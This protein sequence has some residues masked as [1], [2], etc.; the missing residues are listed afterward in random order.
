MTLQRAL[1]AI[2]ASLL[3][4]LLTLLLGGSPALPAP[5]ASAQTGPVFTA[6]APVGTTETPAPSRRLA[7]PTPGPVPVLRAFDKPAQNWLPGHRGVDLGASGDLTAPAAGTVR[8][9]GMLAGRGVLSID[10]GNGLIT[11]FEPVDALV[12]RGSTVAAGQ[13]VARVWEP[14]RVAH[15]GATACFHLGLRL[16]G[17]YVNPLLFLADAAEP[18]RLLPLGGQRGGG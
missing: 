1:P 13:V 6:A 17:E 5:A 14:G 15:C 9:A 2:T 8:F 7:W 16:D 18:V 4:L 10:H 3:T 12:P 11:S